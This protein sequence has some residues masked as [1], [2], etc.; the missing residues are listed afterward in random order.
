ME[1]YPALSGMLRMFRGTDL[2]VL[3]MVN[4]LDVN[5]VIIASISWG[6]TLLTVGSGSSGSKA[7]P[8]ISRVPFSQKSVGMP[9]SSTWLWRYF[10][11][12][13]PMNSHS[14]KRRRSTGWDAVRC[15]LETGPT[16]SVTLS[17]FS[18]RLRGMS[19]ISPLA[20]V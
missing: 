12:D 2:M 17:I 4:N 13:V 8:P 5:L 9:S 18:R 19:R 10:E 16:A 15:T 11:R 3:P 14:S 1:V 7:L 20:W 6:T